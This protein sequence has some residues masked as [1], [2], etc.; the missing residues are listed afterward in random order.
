MQR[1]ETGEEAVFIERAVVMEMRE[2]CR[3]RVLMKL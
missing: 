2:S 3:E 1:K